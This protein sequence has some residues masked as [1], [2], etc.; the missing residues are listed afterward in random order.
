MQPFYLVS[1]Q[2][3][4]T[5]NMK[6][7]FFCSILLITFASCKKVVCDEGLY[8]REEISQSALYG[9]GD[10][11]IDESNL[12]IKTQNDWDDLILKMDAVNDE[13]SNFATI[14]IDFSTHMV[15][16]CFDEAQ[17]TGGHSLEIG[18]V[19]HDG[20]QLSVQVIKTSGEGLVTQVITQPYEI[21]VIDRCDDNVVFN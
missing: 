1:H 14:D 6:S 5:I 4:K 18:T 9:A 2:L 3:R 8:S 19:Q 20:S 12:V 15:I 7:L 11:N 13:S 17:S 21:I 16:A 10:E